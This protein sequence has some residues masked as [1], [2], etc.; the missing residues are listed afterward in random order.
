MRT[1]QLKVTKQMRRK[2]GNRLLWDRLDS[3][4]VVSL[5]WEPLER[6]KTALAV[7]ALKDA[8]L[9]NRQIVFFVGPDDRNTHASFAN[10]PNIRMMLFDQWNAFDVSNGDV[11]MVLEKDIDSFKELVRSWI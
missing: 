7:K 3:H 9:E 6:P 4:N 2:V 5:P 10:L 8:G 11:W 1:R